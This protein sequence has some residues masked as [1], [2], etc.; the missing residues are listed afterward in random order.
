MEGDLAGVDGV[1]RRPL[2]LVDGHKPLLGQPRLEGGVATVA[3]HDGVV[4]L[5]DVVEQI[6]LLEPLDNG[7]AALV[8]VHASE[9]AIALDDHRVLVKDVNLRQVVGLTHGVVV[10]VVSRR[11]LDEAR[12][13]IGVDM[14]IL[15]DGDLAVDDGE[16]DGL[17]HKGGLLGVLRGDSDARV[18][19]HGLGARGGDDDVTRR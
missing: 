4:E 1:K 11:Y 8:A 12:A 7:F 6:V 2:E 18:A 10:G 3:V 16:L 5:F 9:L 15:K 17:T 14:P 13:E 19:K